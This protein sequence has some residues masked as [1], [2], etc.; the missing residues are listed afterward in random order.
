MVQLVR[1]IVFFFLASLGHVMEMKES[2]CSEFS[3][4]PND[5][6]QNL[7]LK[8]RDDCDGML[9]PLWALRRN[10]AFKL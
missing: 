1:A 6:K 4:L 8:N 7:E 9:M 5:G 10:A 2:Y 3:L